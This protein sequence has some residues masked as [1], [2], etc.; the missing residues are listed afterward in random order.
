M[1][2]HVC[3]TALQ[4]RLAALLSKQSRSQHGNY[5]QLTN[6]PLR[7]QSCSEV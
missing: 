3:L 4:T 2:A 6:K 5:K 1:A 7:Q